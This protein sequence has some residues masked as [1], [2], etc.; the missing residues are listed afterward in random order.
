MND[1]MRVLLVLGIGL[2]TLP[3]GTAAHFRLLEP[4]SWLEIN[5]LGDPQKVGPCGGD[6]KGENQKLLTNAVTKVAG[7]SKLT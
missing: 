1:R 5:N 6:P 2:I 4:Q 7:G 3:A